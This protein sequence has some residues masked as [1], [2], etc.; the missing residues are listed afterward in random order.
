M[1]WSPPHLT[2]L[3]L[4]IHVI[5]PEFFSGIVMAIMTSDL[6]SRRSYSK[7]FR[8]NPPLPSDEVVGFRGVSRSFEEFRF[9]VEANKATSSEKRNSSKRRVTI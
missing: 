9:A 8:I 5:P 4:V 2:G 1:A 6:P 7:L 3:I